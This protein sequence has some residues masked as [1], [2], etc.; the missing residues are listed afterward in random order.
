MEQYVVTISREFGALGRTVAQH[1][2]QMLG[3]EFWDRDIVEAAAKR[4]GQSLTLI[5]DTEERASRSAGLFRHRREKMNL[6]SYSISDEVFDTE[7]SIIQDAAKAGSCIIVG[8]CSDYIL[9]NEKNHLSVYLFA[10][11]EERVKNCIERLNMDE[12]TARKT[13]HDMDLARSYYH[14]KY[15]GDSRSV[16]DNKDLLIDSSRF[17]VEGTAQMICSVVQQMFGEAE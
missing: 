15:C 7:C 3:V 16:L 9:R 12:K 4:M 6:T 11:M 5:S 10:P 17:G 1:L 8:R 2:S 13:I 14:K